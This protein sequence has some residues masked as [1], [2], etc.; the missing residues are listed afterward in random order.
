MKTENFDESVRQK[1]ESIDPHYDEKDIDNAHDYII[2]N[3]SRFS[4]R[5]L[6]YLASA[7]FAVILIAGLFTW[8]I[9]Q[10]N[11][12]KQMVQTIDNLKKNFAEAQMKPAVFKRDTVIVKEYIHDVPAINYQLANQL[13]NNSIARQNIAPDN[14]VNILDNKDAS[15]KTNHSENNVIGQNNNV[16]NQNINVTDKNN[17][18]TNQTNNANQVVDNSNTIQKKTD[19]NNSKTLVKS[20]DSIPQDKNIQKDSIA[21][22]ANALSNNNNA[23]NIITTNKDSIKSHHNLFSFMK[24]WHVIA[25]IEGLSGNRQIGYGAKAEILFNDRWGMNIGGRFLTVNNQSYS[26]ENDFYNRIGQDFQTTYKSYVTDA[27]LISDI[28]IHIDIIQIPIALTYH[29]PLPLNFSGLVGIGTSFDL[30]ATQDIDYRHHATIN[31]DELK[32]VAINYH[33]LKFNNAELSAG[34]EKRWKRLCFQLQSFIS[35]EIHPVSYKKENIY[36]GLNL[37]TGFVFGS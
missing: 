21:L 28:R 33:T 30:L 29:F 2:K 36:Y 27:T 25:A 7:S 6:V 17:N 35:P 18:V 24:N 32:S 3:R 20:S 8:N 15:G 14:H 23:G 13:A 9:K 22:N 10:M 1:I 34:I 11:N 16:T 5:G 12:Q 19:D 31:S 26:D 4:K 37:T